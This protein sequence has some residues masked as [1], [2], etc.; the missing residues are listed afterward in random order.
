VGRLTLLCRG[1]DAGLCVRP[2]ATEH[3][4]LHRVS[5][6]KGSPSPTLAQ[7]PENEEKIMARKKPRRKASG[8]PK[9][10]VAALK[11]QDQFVRHDAPHPSARSEGA[12]MRAD[13]PF[14]RVVGIYFELAFRLA[15]CVT[16]FQVWAEQMLAG[17]RL[18]SAWQPR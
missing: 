11:T 12:L 4:S 15:R 2:Q 6:L 1:F 14:S 16:P 10:R 17:Q 7:I 18:L 3:S 8:R 13:S 5:T 9:R